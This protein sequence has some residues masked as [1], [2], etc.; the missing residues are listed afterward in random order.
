[1]NRAGIKEQNLDR[2]VWPGQDFYRFS[3]GGWLDANPLPDDFSSYGTYDELAELNRRQLKD[4]IDGITAQ[5]NAPGSDAA[6]IADLYGLV[7]DTERRD[8]DQF[9]P[10][11]PYREQIRAIKSREEL[12]DMMIELDAYGV[13]GY[14][15]V[16]IGPDLKD[17]RSNIVGM[18]QGGLTLGD[19]E[20]YTDRD[21][22]T[23]NIRKA[24][25]KHVV[26]MLMLAGYDRA[27]ASSRMNVIWRIEM[28]LAKASRNNVQLR[29]P[30][31][32]YHKMSLEELYAQLPGLD[33][34][35]FFELLGIKFV[36]L[37]DVGHP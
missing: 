2:T 28:R 17:S 9:G 13:T 15:D 27:E 25:K 31:A 32:N 7:M 26:R 4:L 1:M 19:K 36:E 12:L 10:L 3:C 24:F 21:M 11:K 35:L 29:D 22:Q 8:R 20:Y 30:A 16:G 6:R 18:S 5:D 34:N 33:W 37:F 14:F 23:R